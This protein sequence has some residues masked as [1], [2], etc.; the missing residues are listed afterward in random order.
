MSQQIA[1]LAIKSLVNENKEP[2]LA[3][4]KGRLT[5]RVPMPIVIDVIKAYKQNPDILKQLTSAPEVKQTKGA[6]SLEQRVTE[7]ETQVALLLK[8]IKQLEESR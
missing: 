8:R 4:V 6:P 1:L 2:T 7:L 3:L 5:S